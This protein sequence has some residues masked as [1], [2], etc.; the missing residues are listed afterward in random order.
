MAQGDFRP[1]AR[2][3]EAMSDLNAI[4]D[5]RS[6]DYARAQAELDTSGDA[7]QQSLSKLVR[8][9]DALLKRRK[10]TR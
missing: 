5:A 9:A 10:G 6:A 4:L 7:E 2:N 3:R 1:M 8:I